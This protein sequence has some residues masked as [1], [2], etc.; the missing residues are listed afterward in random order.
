VKNIVPEPPSRYTDKD[1][2][3]VKIYPD[4]HEALG[5]FV[6]KKGDPYDIIVR[7]LVNF[8]EERA[9]KK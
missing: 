1:K 5:K 4:L 2:K 6:V 9:P 3:V 7:R 8:Y